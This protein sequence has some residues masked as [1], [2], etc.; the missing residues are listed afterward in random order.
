MWTRGT[1]LKAHP[2]WGKSGLSQSPDSPG[3]QFVDL[4]RWYQNHSLFQG[5]IS[6]FWRLKDCAI[7]FL[8][9]FQVVMA[10]VTRRIHFAFITWPEILECGSISDRRW[11]SDLPTQFPS[12]HLEGHLLVP[13]GTAVFQ[14]GLVPGRWWSKMINSFKPWIISR[15]FLFPNAIV[16]ICRYSIPANK[17]VFKR[18]KNSEDQNGVGKGQCISCTEVRLYF[19]F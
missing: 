1:P 10:Y 11:E 2:R 18:E 17:S 3:S 15:N 19:I 14:C 16:R 6:S 13:K 12:N 5:G 4:Q 8:F 9:V 7:Y